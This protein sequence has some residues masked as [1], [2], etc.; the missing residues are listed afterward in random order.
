MPPIRRAPR[1]H[2]QLADEA[3]EFYHSVYRTVQLIPKGRV[4]TY[5]HIA[6]LL[7]HPTWPRRV[8]AALKHL[9][10][11]SISENSEYSEGLESSV[12]NSDT[13][14]WQRVVSAAGKISDRHDGGAGRERQ[15]EVL[16]SEGVVV[17]EDG[18]RT[19]TGRKLERFGVDLE[20]W[21]W[22]PGSI[23]TTRAEPEVKEEEDS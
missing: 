21:G 4:T 23:P 1:Q 6:L 3:T 12:F 20:T 19:V 9:P 11:A 5:G 7:G 14:P 8:G 2:P 17:V 10:S 22:F 13:V 18:G 16:R 15:A